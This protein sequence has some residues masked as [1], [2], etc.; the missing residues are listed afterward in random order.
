M[1]LTE[2]PTHRVF[3]QARSSV[4]LFLVPKGPDGV[5]IYRFGNLLVMNE[6]KSNI[7]YTER[8]Q[9]SVVDILRRDATEKLTVQV[10]TVQT[11]SKH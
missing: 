2:S 8:I 6:T 10:V 9:H 11:N 5:N 4:V 3:S 1:H 7:I